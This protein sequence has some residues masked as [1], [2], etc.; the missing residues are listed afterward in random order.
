MVARLGA[1]VYAEDESIPGILI[2]VHE[3]PH[4]WEGI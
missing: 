3:I 1:G 2:Y 4:F